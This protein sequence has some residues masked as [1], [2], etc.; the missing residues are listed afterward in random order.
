[1][2]RLLNTNDQTLD[3]LHFNH[4]VLPAFVRPPHLHGSGPYV[5]RPLLTPACTL[6]SL[7]YQLWLPFPLRHS[8]VPLTDCWQ[9]S[10]SKIFR[11]YGCHPCI[12]VMLLCALVGFCLLRN[13]T[14]PFMQFLFVGSHICRQLPSYSTSQ[15]TPLL[16]ANTPYCKAC[17]GLAPYSVI[18]MSGAHKK[19]RLC[20]R[21]FVMLFLQT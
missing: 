1:M 4:S 21:R 3:F 15:W 18:T 8:L 9:T 6:Q 19:R 5:L 20:S 7:L 16:L 2:V 12:Y 10:R 14:P 17:S 11:F 13:I